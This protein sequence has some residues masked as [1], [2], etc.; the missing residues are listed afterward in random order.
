MRND[1]SPDSPPPAE[2]EA[3][4]AGPDRRPWF[5]R[6]P[7]LV[8]AAAALAPTA[9]ATWVLTQVLAGSGAGAA[10]HDAKPVA[11]AASTSPAAAPA[12]VPAPAKGP[13]PAGPS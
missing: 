7:T 4:S 9:L 13:S 6:R 10:P 11:A 2:A 8:I 3:A 12:P 5:T 1:D